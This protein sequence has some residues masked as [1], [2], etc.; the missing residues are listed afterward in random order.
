MAKA[1][2]VEGTAGVG[3][4]DVFTVI[5]SDLEGRI[6]AARTDPGDLESGVFCVWTLTK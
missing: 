5:Q 6:L 3:E 4:A 1:G 2:H